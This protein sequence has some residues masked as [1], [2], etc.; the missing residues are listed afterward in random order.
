MY[1]DTLK[2]VVKHFVEEEERSRNQI[3]F[4]VVEDKEKNLGE[5]VSLM[6]VTVNEKP[7]FEAVRLGLRKN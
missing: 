1:R 3:M 2:S 7:R 6:F 4:C 5:K